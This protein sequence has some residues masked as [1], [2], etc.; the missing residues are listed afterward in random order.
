VPQIQ[1]D[2][3]E[4]AHITVH[5]TTSPALHRRHT[6]QGLSEEAGGGVDGS[7]DGGDGGCGNN[8]ASQTAELSQDAG[9]AGHQSVNQGRLVENPLV[10]HEDHLIG[11]LSE[12][13]LDLAL[14]HKKTMKSSPSPTSVGIYIQTSQWYNVFCMRLDTIV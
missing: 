7:E 9:E 6:Y 1:Q 4:A 5:I 3:I 14:L 13:L 8:P 12:L 10:Q 11:L 2:S